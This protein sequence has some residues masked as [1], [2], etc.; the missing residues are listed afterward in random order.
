MSR[1]DRCE[2]RRPTLY[3]TPDEVAAKYKLEPVEIDFLVE[4]T[5]NGHFGDGSERIQRL[6]HWYNV[7]QAL[8]NG[9]IRKSKRRFFK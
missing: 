4:A 3:L 1:C 8:V 5:L 7:V 6:G 9:K 2:Y